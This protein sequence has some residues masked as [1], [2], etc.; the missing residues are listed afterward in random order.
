MRHFR[1]RR[2]NRKPRY[3]IPV[4]HEDQYILLMKWMKEHG[5]SCK[6]CCLKPAFFPDTGRGLMAR[7]NFRPGDLIVEIPR[8]LL[9]TP[10]DV[11][12]TELGPLIKRQLQKPTPYQAVCAFLI[13]ERTNGKSSFWYPYINVLPKDF[14]TPAFCFA[15]QAQFDLLPSQARISA[16]KQLQDIRCAFESASCLFE[17]IE[18]TFPWY[19][20]VFDF[21]SFLWAWFVINSRSVY[22]EPSG[23]ETFD[24][25]SKDD[26]ALAPFLD[27]LNHSPGAEVSAGF[28]SASNTYQIKTL[29][30]YRTYDQVFIHYGPHDNVNLLLEYGFV[31]PSNP[32]DV[33]CF[34]LGT[35]VDAVKSQHQGPLTCRRTRE[36]TD[37]WEV[38][39]RTLKAA[40]LDL[41]L[42]C[43]MS[44]PSWNLQT[45]LRVLCMEYSEIV[46][47][48]RVIAENNIPPSTKNLIRGALDK[49]TTDEQERVLSMLQILDRADLGEKM[50]DYIQNVRILW[51]ERLNI[52]RATRAEL[53]PNG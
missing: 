53:D 52:L 7:K 9:V 36:V 43:S 31:I 5:F 24:P 22:M 15:T 28:D 25:K 6:R 10:K 49:L 17:D 33:V 29:D 3:T 37:L 23:C 32:H 46:N 4:D 14:T 1:K 26:F 13:M 50:G 2:K 27:L 16:T 20:G 44:G 40:N 51:S 30:S 8:R 12:N 47:W 38:K 19:R 48:K 41:D 45:A 34:E 35:A 39:S 42:S 18:R 11:L 21:G